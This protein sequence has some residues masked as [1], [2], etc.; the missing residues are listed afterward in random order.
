WSTH[1]PMLPGERLGVIGHYAARNMDYGWEMLK[2]ACKRLASAGCTLAVGPM[3]GNT[4]RRYRFITERGDAPPFFL[5]PD[6]PEDWPQHFTTA[7]FTPL[8]T[9]S[10][11]L[12]HDLEWQDPRLPRIRERITAEGVTVRH[13]DAGRYD[14][15]LDAIYAL[16]LSSFA[17]NFLY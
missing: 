14:E 16:S 15:E 11:A 10:S 13:I 4:W 9:Y 8:A 17:G 3:D 6:N 7:G 12:T 1:V 5:E 2:E